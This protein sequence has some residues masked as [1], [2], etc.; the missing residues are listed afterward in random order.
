MEFLYYQELTTVHWLSLK[1][2]RPTAPVSSIYDLHIQQQMCSGGWSRL[3]PFAWKNH[4]PSVEGVTGA[5][6]NWVHTCS[7]MLVAEMQQRGTGVECHRTFWRVPHSS[8][9]IACAPHSCFRKR[10]SPANVWF[11]CSSLYL[12]SLHLPFISS[13]QLAVF[14]D[15]GFPNLPCD[16]ILFKSSFVLTEAFLT[17]SDPFLITLCKETFNL[18]LHYW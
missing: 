1:T 5:L 18:V 4:P 15:L 17:M 2:C 14:I 3:L 11:S 10:M 16:D 12:L 6:S 7:H 9:I 8:T 13:K